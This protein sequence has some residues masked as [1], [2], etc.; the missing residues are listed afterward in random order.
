LVSKVD[1][2]DI[3]PDSQREKGVWIETHHM[4]TPNCKGG[5]EMK[6]NH[7][8]KKKR[9]LMSSQQYNPFYSDQLAKNQIGNYY[10]RT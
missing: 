4:I 9:I 2:R 8:P 7:V 5:W 10:S 6:S 3:I 1:L